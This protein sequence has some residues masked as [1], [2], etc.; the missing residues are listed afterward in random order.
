MMLVTIAIR[1]L[2]ATFAL[3]IVGSA[4]VVILTAFEDFKLLFKRDK[5]P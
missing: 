2:E 3:G 1:T 4:I 5:E